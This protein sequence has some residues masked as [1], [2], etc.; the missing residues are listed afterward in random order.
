MQQLGVNTIRVYNL[1]PSLNHDMC[2][3][4]FNAV[5]IYMLLDVN[6]PLPGQSLN[7]G[8]P[9]SS[10][11]SQYLT[12]IFGIVEAFKDYPNTL[13]FFAGNEVINDDANAATVPPYLRAVTRDL[14]NY[15]ANHS[16]RTIPVGYS[17]ADVSNVLV[18]TWQYLQCAINGSTSDMSRSDFF[19]INSYSWCGNATFDS[20]GYNVLISEFMNT[21][22]PVFF[23]EYGCNLVL[24]RV[25]T[26]VP[27]LYGPLMTPVLSGGLI[28]EYSQEVSDYGLVVLYDNGTAQIRQD[29]DN[30]QAQY[31]KLNITLLEAGNSTATALNPPTCSS[32]LITTSSG[33][34]NSFDIPPVPSGGQELIDNGISNPNNGKLVTV[35]QDT[36]SQQ[37]YSSSGGLI[38]NLAIKP[39]P[40]DESNMP[41]GQDTS[42]AATTSSTASAAIP[43]ATKKGAGSRKGVGILGLMGAIVF[44]LL[45]CI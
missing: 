21:T 15:I 6:S 29:Y 3:S 41:N 20:S 8:D 1:D 10:Y 30:L 28:Y 27:V 18:D 36:V 26:E 7:S 40:N 35:T 19:G 33:F 4:I 14:K 13:G 24:P 45:I 37:V 43:K 44:P 34:N 22:I 16:N 11:N 42:G 2:V 5:G 38:Q 32:S 23:S 17:A 39:L 9:G 31:N 25:F 12:Q